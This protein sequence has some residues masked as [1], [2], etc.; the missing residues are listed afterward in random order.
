LFD[1]SEWQSRQSELENFTATAL[2]AAEST[3]GARKSAASTISG[4]NRTRVRQRRKFILEE[5]AKR[6]RIAHR[7][8]RM[9][10]HFLAI[11]SH[12]AATGRVAA[13]KKGV[14]AFFNK[15]RHTDSK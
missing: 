11:D 2:V 1:G 6:H 14:A 9:N 12:V 5:S 4:N 13:Y 3:N 8:L 15:R 10:S 7:P